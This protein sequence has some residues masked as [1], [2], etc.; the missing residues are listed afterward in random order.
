MRPAVAVAQLRWGNWFNQELFGRPTTWPWGLEIEP[1]RTD[2]RDTCHFATFQPTLLYES[3]WC[4]LIFG[5]ITFLGGGGGACCPRQGPAT[6]TL[7]ITI[8]TLERIFMELLHY[9]QGQPA[10]SASA[11]NALLSAALWSASTIVFVRLSQRGPTPALASTA[12]QSAPGDSASGESASGESRL[13]RRPR[14]AWPTGAQPPRSPTPPTPT[15]LRQRPRPSLQPRDCRQRSHH[16]HC[17]LGSRRGEDLRTGDTVVR[18]LDASTS[19]PRGVHRDHGAVGFGKDPL[20]ALLAG[21]DRLTSGQ[22]FGDIES[23][24]SRQAAH[25]VA[26]RSVGF[27]FQAFNLDADAHRAREI[28]LP[29]RWRPQARPGVAS[30]TS[31]TSSVYAIA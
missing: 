13:G 27:V 19:I 30:T 14:S 23:A 26:T 20:V 25:G 21:L 6:F 3:L 29:N 8:R 16:H 28:T 15:A 17:G 12:V 10:S 7:Y 11:S 1:S 22:F 31:S 4:L 2:P 18:A 5:V 9:R 24:R